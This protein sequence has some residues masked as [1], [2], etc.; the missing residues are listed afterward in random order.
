MDS[1]YDIQVLLRHY[2]KQGVKAIEATRL[3]NT[4]EG[5]NSINIRTAQ[6]WFK[7]LRKKSSGQQSIVNS[8]ALLEA[9]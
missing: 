3:I 9:V 8:V 5:A 7:L 1:K 6:N 4:V 2:W